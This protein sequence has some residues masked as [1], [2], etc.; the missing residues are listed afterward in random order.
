MRATI[1]KTEGV[2]QGTDFMRYGKNKL[3][4]QVKKGGDVNALMSLSGVDRN[5]SKIILHGGVFET[6]SSSTSGTESE[7]L[8][9]N[10]DTVAY[11]SPNTEVIE[12]TELS[13]LKKFNIKNT[14]G[15]G[16]LLNQDNTIEQ[17]CQCSSLIALEGPLIS[18]E[19]TE[20]IKNN[21]GLQYFMPEGVCYGDLSY[22]GDST[23]TVTGGDESV[24]TWS[25]NKNCSSTF[26]C[27][28]LHF[29]DSAS[30]DR[31]LNDMAAL[32]VRGT[33]I[34]IFGE[35][36]SASDTAVATLVTNGITLFI[37]GTRITNS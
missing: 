24:Y 2:V 13:N 32:T 8:I 26:S 17:F 27:D 23:V 9:L 4:I 37:N 16:L 29:A 22:I 30:I 21:Q 35:R 1:I 18:G 6:T 28:K 34:K 36:T 7:K 25:G 3:Y 33:S 5:V 31:F 15:L 10:T 11:I 19:I 20:T 12:I 14:Y